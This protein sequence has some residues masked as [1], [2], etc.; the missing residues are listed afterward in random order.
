VVEFGEISLLELVRRPGLSLVD[1]CLGL[2]LGDTGCLVQ[3]VSGGFD[4]FYGCDGIWV[5]RRIAI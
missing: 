1:V 4:D 3:R 5:V 2:L